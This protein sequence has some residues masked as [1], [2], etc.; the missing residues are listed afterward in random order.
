MRKG[1]V[2]VF[3]AFITLTALSS[4]CYSGN[5]NAAEKQVVILTSP[6]DYETMEVVGSDAYTVQQAKV[7]TQP[8]LDY[9]LF[10]DAYVEFWEKLK[11]YVERISSLEKIDG[12]VNLKIDYAVDKKFYYFTATFDYFRF[13]RRR[14]RQ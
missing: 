14:T 5:L 1:L 12:I 13:R 4:V 10:T 9:V 6:P 7:I 8:H 11:R 2:V 3:L